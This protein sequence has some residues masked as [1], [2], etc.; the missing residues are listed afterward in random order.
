MNDKPMPVS[1]TPSLTV[2]LTAIEKERWVG[3]EDYLVQLKDGT[4]IFFHGDTATY[5]SEAL[6]NLDKL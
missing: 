6:A 2:E 4:N 1:L 5:A 3:S